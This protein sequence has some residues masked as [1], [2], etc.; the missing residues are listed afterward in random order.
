M[1]ILYV[2]SCWTGF[3][4]MLYDASEKLVGMPAFA[5]V[6]ESL[7]EYGWQ[8]DMIIYDYNIANKNKIFN[9]ALE[10]LKKVKILDT[11]YYKNE[12]K[13]LKVIHVFWAYNKIKKAVIKACRDCKYDFIYG[14]AELS[15]AA[16]SIAKKCK[17][18]FGQRRYGDTY[19]SLIQKKG[20]F[21]SILSQPINYFSYKNSKDFMIATNDGSQI[22]V[23][24]RTINKNK[25]PYP[26]YLWLNGFDGNSGIPSNI[27]SGKIKNKPYLLYVARII[28]PKRQHLA[29]EI[30][31]NLQ[32]KGILIHLYLAGQ[33][34]SQSYY[35]SIIR[36][37]KEYDIS[38][39]VH[40]IGII[41]FDEILCYSV[42]A[43]ACLSF[44]YPCNLGNVLIECLSSGSV[45]IS[46]DDGSLDDIISNGKNGFLVNDMD[47]ASNVVEK[48]LSDENLTNII[49]INAKETAKLKFKTWQE[50]IDDEISL[51]EKTIK[52]YQ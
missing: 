20:L 35:D 25:N 47:E 42:N 44:Y 40:Y 33:K 18:P 43:V 7:V 26:L 37:A 10:W 49:K 36:K 30:I 50:R 38:N 19:L 29:L 13:I 46:C 3:D 51:I 32:K 45:I 6:L 31:K 1:K 2:T 39:L 24:Y 41:D 23:L 16:N 14:H 48:L 5:R 12:K 52:N 27:I 21:Y 8:V 17:I 11:V 9:I 15:E 28:N 4:S 22:D 34:S